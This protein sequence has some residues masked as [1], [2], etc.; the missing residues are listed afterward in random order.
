MEPILEISHLKSWKNIWNS[1]DFESLQLSF[2]KYAPDLE[3]HLMY[4]RSLF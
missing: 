3:S 2:Q 4:F 1:I